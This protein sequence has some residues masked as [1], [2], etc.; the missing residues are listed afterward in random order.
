MV[1]RALSIE[2]GNLNSASLITS[3]RADYKDIDLTFAARPSGDVY[4]KVDA[5]AVRQAVKNVLLTNPGEKPFRPSFGAGLNALIF[6]LADDEAEQEIDEVIRNA[7]ANYEPRARV[8]DTL[9]DVQPDRNS[10]KIQVQFQVLNTEETVVLE[11]TL[12]RLR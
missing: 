4:K 2:D 6:E 7:I 3:R 8:L 9:I 1:T 11:T 12:V 5:A 10:I